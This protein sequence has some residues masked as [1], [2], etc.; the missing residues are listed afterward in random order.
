MTT[1][2]FTRRQFLKTTTG[3]GAAVTLAQFMPRQLL[4]AD[5]PQVT[6]PAPTPSW[7]DKPMRWAQLTLVE[8]DPG[9]FDLAFWLDYFKRTRSDAV[10]LSGGGCVAYYPTQI[11]FHHRSKWLGDRDVLG[12]LIAGCRK[13]GMVV[14]VRTDPHATYDDVQAAH[15]DWIAVTADGQPRRHWASPEMWVTCGLGPYNFEFMTE[16]KKE[17][18]SRY[19]VDGVF[20]NRWD[21]SGM[22][23]CEHCVK[24]FKDASGFNLPRTNNPQDPARRAYILWRQQRLFDLW[25][26]WDRAVRKINPDSCVIPNT[27]G[28]AT[29]SLDMKKIGELAPTLMADRQARRGLMAPWAIG[30]NAKEYRATLSMKPI[31][32]IFSVGVEEPYRWKDSV[33]NADEIRLWVA[34][35]VANGMRPWFTKFGGVLHDERWLKPVEDIYRRLAGWEHYL[36]NESPL[37]RVGVVYSQQTAWFVGNRGSARVEDHINGWYQALIE[38]RIPFE[39]VHDRLLD[40]AHVGQ[41]KTLILPNVVALSDAQCRQIEEFV[42]GGGSVVATHETSLCDEW[43]VRRNNFGLAGLFG[44]NYGGKIEAR[45][46]NAYLRLEHEANP[47]HPLLKGLEDA[48]RIIHGVSR[49]EVEPCEK[50]PTAPLT[51]IPSY[52]D[53]PMEMVYPRVTKTD[54]AQVFLRELVASLTPSLSPSKGERVA[55]RPGEGSS[56]SG[57]VIYFP[58][59]I[60]RTFWE[61]LCV[62]H[63]KLLRNAVEWATYEEPPITVSGPGV[64]DVTV[65]RQKSS[66]TVHLVNLTNPMMMKGP[67]RELIP[68]GE[69]KVRIRLPDGLKPRKVRLLAA[70]KTPKFTRDG[71]YLAVTVPSLLDHEIVAIDL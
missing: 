39:L 53:L 66:L 29:S 9:K 65:W 21:G 10:C 44:V 68:V 12:E 43:G 22:C 48:P 64:L 54:I 5:A 52:P 14:I 28:G 50:F 55:A 27:G 69:Q 63:F 70:G 33:Q 34:D 36:R 46:Q 20:I 4:A 6:L 31:V 40:A 2:S 15:P 45:M 51:L 16:V 17:I 58:W 8:D 7:V 23:Y 32:G 13:L 49:V 62:D 3:A 60:D 38:A 18:M 59:D 37:A 42:R 61:V 56:S 30:M 71:S 25:Q 57:R 26:T 19:R 24:N 41:F 1:P 11:P 47:H 67:V 35:L